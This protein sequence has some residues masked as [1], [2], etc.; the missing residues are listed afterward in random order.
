MRRPVSGGMRYAPNARRARSATTRRP[1]MKKTS[2]VQVFKNEIFKE[3]KLTI[4]LDLGDRWSF[5]CVLDEAGQVILE[6]K[7]P[8][9][10]EAMK[11]T[12]GK[13]PR[14]LIT[15]ETGTHSPWVSRQLTELGHEVIVAHAQKGRLITKSNRKDDRHDARTLA[16]LA[17]IDPA[18]LGPVRH[19]SVQ[20][21]LHLTV[22]RARAELV[23][24]RTALVNAARGLVKSYG[25][26]LPRCGSYQVSEKLAKGL[27]A[28]L[29]EVLVP[30]LKEIES[31]NEHIQEYDERMEEIAKEVYPQV[32]LLK[33][34]KGVGTQ[35]ALTYVLTIEDPYRFPKSRAVGCFL[36]LRPGRRNSGKSEPQKKISKEGDR[37]LRTMM[38]Q[39]AHYIL[40]PLGEDSDLRRW[41]WKLAERG[42]KNAKKRAVVAVARKLAVLLHRLWVSGEVYE[43]LRNHREEK[44][45]AA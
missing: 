8:T 31:L 44:R 1:A 6:Q 28:E 36:G 38:V 27:S 24:A 11:Q 32:S 16:R 20:A 43:P 15:L 2:T 10:P 13:I 18:L 42:G 41:G 19:R 9:T 29:R 7:L 34:V 5:Y 4:G 40:G 25:Q 22:I 14:S 3:Q 30:L 12:F 37:Y 33:Q 17:R 39:G 23:S 26:R 21:Q 35:I 45:A